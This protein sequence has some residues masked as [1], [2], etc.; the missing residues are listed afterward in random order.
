[1]SA[2]VRS[3]S[4]FRSAA[5]FLEEAF[6][7]RQD[8]VLIDRLRAMKQMAETKASLSDVSGIS[9]DVILE[10]LVE[11]DVKPETVA[12]LS[13]VP[14]IEVAWADGEV[15]ADE[16]KAVLAH[17]DAKG[18]QP[19]TIE[20]ELLDRWLT[21]RPEPKLLE[22]W[23]TYVKGLCE[24]LDD[25]EKALLKQELLRNAQATAEASGGFLGIGRISKSERAMLDTLAGSF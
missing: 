14:L 18:I 24:T 7:I 8:A 6:F 11:L 9:N 15:D 5:R 16:R 12:A 19:G 23:Q 2:S 25:E 4:S 1:M 10:R 21:H 20:H 17:A 13:A 22:A 3:S